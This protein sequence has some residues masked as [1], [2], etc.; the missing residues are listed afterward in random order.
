MAAMNV[1]SGYSGY[2]EQALR[3]EPFFGAYLEASQPTALAW[4][5]Q[6]YVNK[7]VLPAGAAEASTYFLL[8]PR[9]PASTPHRPFS[10]QVVSDEFEGGVVVMSLTFQGQSA[11]RPVYFLDIYARSTKEVAPHTES[12]MRWQSAAHEAVRRS[13]AMALTDECRRLF[14][15][16]Q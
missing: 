4:V 15:E 5:G 10:L 3:V 13:F 12:I 2:E 6:R 11:E 1:L 14:E 16:A 7:I 8:Y 9:L